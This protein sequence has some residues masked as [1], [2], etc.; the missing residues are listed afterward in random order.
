MRKKKVLYGL[1]VIALLLPS[2]FSCRRIADDEHYAIPAWLKGS[3]WEVLENDGNYSSFLKAIDLTGYKPIVSGKS[4]L[5]V[6]APD[7]KAFS[8]YL[9]EEGYSSVDEMFKTDPQ[10]LSKMVGFHLLYYSFKWDNLVN[11]RPEEGDGATALEKLRNAGSYYKF[12]THSSDP[13]SEEST[14]TGTVKVYHFECF[15][16]VFNTMLFRGK[17]INAKYNYEYFFPETE[18]T[19]DK[20]TGQAE[21]FNVANASVKD[22]APVVTDNGY[23]YHIDQV[24]RPME[25]IYTELKENEEYSVFFELFN[26]YSNYEKD[27]Q[28]T[29]DFGDGEDIYLHKH[30]KLQNI[31]CEW[32]VTDYKQM[33]VL[34]SNGYNVFAPSNDAVDNF[35]VSYWKPGCGYDNLSKLDNLI[36]RYFIFQTYSQEQFIAF[37]EEISNGTVLTSFGT[38]INIDPEKVTLRKICCNGTLYGMDDMTPPAIFTSVIGSAFRERRF[39]PFLY[40]LDGSGLVLALASQNSSFVALIPD[41]AQFRGA[42]IHF[43]TIAGGHELQVLGDDGNYVA[44]SSS[45]MQNL[46]N[47]NVAS[48]VTELKRSG[49]Q[50]VE[51][52]KAFNYWYL[53]DGKLTTNALFNNQLNPTYVDEIYFDFKEL[54]YSDSKTDWDNGKAYTYTSPAVFQPTSDEGLNHTLAVCNDKTYPYYLFSQLLTKAGLVEEGMLK[55]VMAD[56]RFITFVP[57]NEAIREH[58]KEIPGCSKCSVSD[59][60][61]LSGT[62]TK[63]TLASYLRSYFIT[64][65]MTPF[66]VYP[67]P[68]SGMSGTFQTAGIYKMNIVDN[69]TTLKVN[70]I[71]TEGEERTPASIYGTEKFFSLPFAYSDGAFHLIDNIL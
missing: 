68:G 6:M 49:L 1:L 21:G 36:M 40:A 18:W 43:E 44:M 8:D 10:E 63:A 14:G 54:P 65:D 45:A 23:L 2:V 12:R 25:S 42:D 71:D 19:G 59:S 55:V 29:T 70:F 3:A 52:N 30:D 20:H 39:L 64:S 16:P 41:S 47:M 11:F 4:I 66:S 17:G 48:S 62:P 38:P 56:A 60:Y 35:F 22:D 31:A 13:I 58:I 67:Y 53:V 50:V 69:G 24:L 33:A 51:T 7:D 26:S 9:K 37:P 34:S 32:P 15:L 28:L 27:N 61:V 5:T 57:T 46:V